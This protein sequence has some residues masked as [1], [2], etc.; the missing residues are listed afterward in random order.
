MFLKIYYVISLLAFIS[1]YLVIH[2]CINIT[3][4]K[5]ANNIE[6]LKNFISDISKFESNID[7][8]RGR[9]VIDAKS[10]MGMFSIDLSQS[11]DILIYSDNER[12][13]KKFEE[14]MKKYEV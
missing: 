11:V 13:L 5:F 12:E 4:S 2:R 7:A 1:F 14:V 10:I 3:K 6:T 9:Y 8:V